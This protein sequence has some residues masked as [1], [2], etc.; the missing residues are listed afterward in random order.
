MQRHTKSIHFIAPLMCGTLVSMLHIKSFEAWD[1][2]T[3]LWESGVSPLLLAV[4]GHP[5][6]FRFLTAY[7]G[8]LLEDTFPTIGFSLYI[9][10]FF[11]LNVALW[12]HVSLLA[13]RRAPSIA[14]W[15]VFF[16]AH[17]FMN[18]RGVIAWTGWLICVLLCIRLTRGETGGVK[19][20]LLV[21]LSCWLAAVSTGVF[22]VVVMALLLFYLQYR[23]RSRGHIV[24][25]LIIFAVTMPLLYYV[26]EYLVLAIKKNIDFFGGGLD[27]VIHMLAHGLGRVLFGSEL[28]AVCLIA[29]AAFL[30]LFLI[31]FVRMRKRPFTP[32]EQL[33]GY[34]IFGG[35]FGLTV[36]T[37]AVPIFLIYQQARRASLDAPPLALD[38]SPA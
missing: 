16:A 25:K 18:G 4:I 28:L 1:Q 24:R 7:P 30:L 17:F 33:L 8:F 32:L 19:P 2:V 36:L 12:R 23:R 21:A 27:G 20:L 3:D 13:S 11:A 6:F 38:A 29:L 34:A 26:G 37:L 9:S 22:I 35:M 14:G 31:M 10:V 15:A 5:H